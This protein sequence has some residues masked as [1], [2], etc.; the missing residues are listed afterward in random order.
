MTRVITGTRRAKR[1]A[2]RIV[3]LVVSLE[4][5]STMVWG[6][7][8]YLGSRDELI[9][10]IGQRLEEM[11]MR[12]SGTMA[13]FFDPLKVELEAVSATAQIL[14]GNPDEE[15]I[16]L[17][18]VLRDRPAIDALAIHYAQHG[19]SIQVSRLKATGSPGSDSLSG[20]PSIPTDANAATRTPIFYSPYLDPLVGMSHP[21]G[22][23]IGSAVA[24]INLKWLWHQVQR[25]RVGKTGYVYLLDDDLTLIGHRDHSLVLRQ[26]NGLKAGLP[27]TM[28][29]R[30]G[31]NTLHIYRNFNGEQVTGVAKY[32]PRQNWW[33]VVELP[34]AEGLASLNRIIARFVTALLLAVAVSI[35]V[36]LLVTRITLRPL[37]VLEQGIQRLAKGESEVRVTVTGDNEIARLAHAFNHM[38]ENTEAQAALLQQQATHDALTGLPNR[39]YLQ[40]QL[41]GALEDLS[42]GK[43][44]HIALL[45]L[46]LD[47]FKEVNDALGHSTG[48]ELLKQL[49]HKLASRCRKPCSIARLGGDEFALLLPD[50]RG[51]R[52]AEDAASQV[53]AVLNE[54]VS[55]DELTLRVDGSIGIAIAPEDGED[56]STL[57]RLADIAMYHAK[58]NGLGQSCYQ[59]HID[60]SSTRRLQLLG[61]LA[62]AIEKGQLDLH[63]QPKVAIRD[64]RCYAMEALARWY[65]PEFGEI[66]PIEFI[67]LAELG[68]LMDG[69][70]FRV[71]QQGL[72]DRMLWQQAGHELD[73]SINIS[74]RNLLDEHFAQRVQE[75]LLHAGAPAECLTLEVTESSIMVDPEG[76]R[77]A[78]AALRNIG[79]SISVDDYGTGYS[80][81]SYLKMLAL[82]EIK[83]DKSFVL[84]MVRDDN[85]AI[86]VRSTIELAHNLGM[87]VTAEGVEDQETLDIL[88]ILDCDHVQGF[89]LSRPLSPDDLPDWL[90]SQQ[91]GNFTL[92]SPPRE[93]SVDLPPP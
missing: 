69:L 34:V 43:V 28:F 24:W 75:M 4:L 20:Y 44:R 46:D 54:P 39:Q 85:D 56:A 68:G 47:H 77:R 93:P 17:N 57:L 18:R 25:A 38:A 78:L 89:H 70:T 59:A 5:L 36:V 62:N 50:C 66:S 22:N 16:L 64:G 41:Q 23:G 67:P 74:T 79:V 10:S 27:P 63:Y 15:V 73:L 71:I 76:A 82:D 52:E 81:L 83:I 45:L 72:H 21:I 1:L 51:R 11:A 32:D 6:S 2:N 87:R 9:T 42:S 40:R 65:H 60:G 33:V 14:R 48:D 61:D 31:G 30:D 53:L 92:V 86:I 55:L 7:L 84:D 12:T 8:T 19:D 37:E 35:I 26:L 13:S 88:A 29:Q 3:L 90:M 80:S 91:P 49:S 58:H